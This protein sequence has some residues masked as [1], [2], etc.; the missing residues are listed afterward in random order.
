MSLEFN[1]PNNF[2][3][4]NKG[5]Y[6]YTIGG[7]Y[8]TA[9]PNWVG[10]QI[11][12]GELASNRENMS[13]TSS[14]LWHNKVFR[15]MVS[16]FYEEKFWKK[17]KL[18]QITH[19]NTAEELFIFGVNSGS[20]NAIRKAQKIVGATPDGL[21]GPDTIKKLNAYDPEDFDM[22]FDVVELQY[23]NDIIKNK[24]SFAMFKD[25]WRNR[26]KAV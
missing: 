12:L 17:M 22:I 11:V 1:N 25:G 10:W 16:T 5:E 3:H 21:I 13:L 7:I 4:K 20:R 18:D 15:G 26:A 9:H 8:K 24:P 23:Y 19:Q 2:L 6:D 14:R